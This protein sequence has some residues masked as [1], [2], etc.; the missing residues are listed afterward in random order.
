MDAQFVDFA[1]LWTPVAYAHELKRKPLPVK[2]AG[3]RLVLW[4]TE[5]GVQAALD[6]CPHR[7]VQLSLGHVRPDGCLEC[8]FHGW[9]F[10]PDGACTH[11]PMNPRAHLA[12]LGLA[13]LPVRERGGMIWVFT[14]VGAEDPGEPDLPEAFLRDDLARYDYAETWSCHWTRA[15]ENML[16]YPHLP[17]VHRT[18]IGAGVRRRLKEDSQAELLVHE[19]PHGFEI[20]SHLEGGGTGLLWYR[21][22]GMALET[23]PP[24]KG[25]MRVHAF[26]VPVDAEHTRMMTVTVRG[27]GVR[28]PLYWLTDRFTVFI[29]RQDRAV[30][31][32]HDPVEVPPPA[33]ELSVGTDRPTLAFRQWY[34]RHCKG[35][36]ERPADR[37]SA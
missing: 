23:L 25:Y 15:M 10:G 34:L 29:L 14:E 36:H 1:R 4:R 21:P 27:F 8:P 28:N 19:R 24:D 30:T 3:E 17:F 6:R 7:G 18:T 13:T 16:D 33:D 20:E 35:S 32:S 2:V 5:Q 26:C 22:N 12:P 9:R 11:V 31:E 37:A